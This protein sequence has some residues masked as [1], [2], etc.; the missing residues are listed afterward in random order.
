MIGTHKRAFQ[1]RNGRQRFTKF[2]PLGYYSSTNEKASL[3][4]LSYGHSQG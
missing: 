4:L 3:D 1:R 2:L